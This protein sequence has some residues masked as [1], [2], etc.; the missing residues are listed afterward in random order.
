MNKCD[1]LVSYMNAMVERQN[2]C[3][4]AAEVTT[5]LA[6]VALIDQGVN[7]EEASMMMHA[8]DVEVSQRYPIGIIEGI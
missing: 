8:A 2:G 7:E 6:R 3:P 4:I 1:L 5:E